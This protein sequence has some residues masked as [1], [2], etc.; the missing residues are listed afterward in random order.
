MFCKTFMIMWPMW[1][2]LNVMILTQTGFANDAER[3]PASFCK[4]FVKNWMF[5]LWIAYELSFETDFNHAPILWCSQSQT[6]TAIF[7][8][9]SK[10][11]AHSTPFQNLIH[12][13]TR[14]IFINLVK[15]LCCSFY[16]K[17]YTKTVND[18]VHAFFSAQPQR[19]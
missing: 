1:R 10:C 14:N 7:T 17:I 4:T 15:Y 3:L 2:G 12:K 16:A 9:F 6:T 5:K 8:I 11:V 13:N 19:C 18:T